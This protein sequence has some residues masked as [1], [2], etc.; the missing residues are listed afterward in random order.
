MTTRARDYAR[1]VFPA[2]AILEDAVY[3]LM[4]KVDQDFVVRTVKRQIFSERQRYIQKQ[5]VDNAL[6][7]SSMVKMTATNIE[8]TCRGRGVSYVDDYLVLLQEDLERLVNVSIVLC[9]SFDSLRESHHE[10]WA[11][12]KTYM[13]IAD[14]D[15]AHAMYLSSD[16]WP[17][18]VFQGVLMQLRKDYPNPVDFQHIITEDGPDIRTVIHRIAPGIVKAN[19]IEGHVADAINRMPLVE[20]DL[21]MPLLLF[22]YAKHGNGKNA[23]N[24]EC[25]RPASDAVEAFDILNSARF[26]YDALEYFGFYGLVRNA[27]A[28]L[29]YTVA[30]EQHLDKFGH[31]AE[32]ITLY[33]FGLLKGIE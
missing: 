30:Q 1:K 18:S 11:F 24:S 16:N 31:A 2:A 29:C 22:P 8:T 27:I 13:P 17:F 33:Q 10:L 23:L 6:L 12:L 20:E 14:A 26:L 9:D 5:D 15:N 25:K 4:S 3:A 7:T 19:T 32:F 28:E 21:W